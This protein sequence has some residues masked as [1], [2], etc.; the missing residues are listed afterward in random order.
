LLTYLFKQNFSQATSSIRLKVCRNIIDFVWSFCYSYSPL[1]F[2]QNDIHPLI[3]F[4]NYDRIHHRQTSTS[5]SSSSS[6]SSSISSL[7]PPSSSLNKWQLMNTVNKLSLQNNQSSSTT[8]NNDVTITNSK[9]SSSSSS[10]SSSIRRQCNLHDTCVRQM[11]LLITKLMENTN[12]I[13]D[14][15]RKRFKNEEINIKL[16]EI[17]D[18]H[19]DDIL[20]TIYIEKLL[21]ILSICHSSLDSSPSISLN[22]STK[23]LAASITSTNQYSSFIYTTIHLNLNDLIS[24]GDSI[25]YCLTTFISQPNYLLPILCHYLTTNPLLSSLLLLFIIY[26]IH[27]TKILFQALNHYKLLDLLV[28]NL[29][30]YSNYLINQTQIPSIQRIYDQRQS[31]NNTMDIDS[32]NLS[33]QCQ[34]ICSNPN[35][36][37]PEILL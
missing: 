35:A 7:I 14:Q 9:S 29:I 18:E 27:N 30:L 33:S 6:S 32:I 1:S 21:S 2:T 10:S 37:S 24:V 17:E 13:I 12:Q 22:S 19:N 34:I 15:Q 5:S 28:N 36:S 25:Y 11:I 26:S 31:L 8:N 4:L 20:E 23:F 3:C 16:N